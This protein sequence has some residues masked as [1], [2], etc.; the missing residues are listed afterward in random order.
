MGETSELHLPDLHISGFRGIDELT[1]PRLGRVTLLVGKNGVGKTSVLDAVRVYAAR[2]RLTRLLEVLEQH[3]EKSIGG[4]GEVTPDWS[5]LFTGRL[6][7]MTEGAIKI[8]SGSQ[9][10]KIETTALDSEQEERVR[11]RFGASL[12]DIPGLRLS[13]GGSWKVFPLIPGSRRGLPNPIMLRELESLQMNRSR[14][15]DEPDTIPC[16]SLGPDAPTGRQVADL[17]DQALVHGSERLAI[18]AVHIVFSGVGDIV[19]Q[20]RDGMPLARTQSGTTRVPLKS[21]GEGAM[22]LFGAGLALAS[23]RNGFLL[24]DEAENGLHHTVHRDFWR[25]TLQSAVANN[26]QVIATTHS[27]D[28]VHGF[29]QAVLECEDVD[30]IAIRLERDDEGLYCVEYSEKE[31]QVLQEQRP[32]R[33]EM[34]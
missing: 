18:D 4:E 30:G 12:V 22:R 20:T 8:Q 17:W 13:F 16:W 34:R 2:L 33:I 6:G 10:L 27:E 19:L 21:L 11:R 29:A 25:M 1:I 24:I 15:S 3:D 28:C 5:A 9:I 31:L 32:Y 23:A 14:S 7:V 26:V